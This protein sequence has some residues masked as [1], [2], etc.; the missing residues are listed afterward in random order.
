MET[1][2]TPHPL[3]QELQN[4]MYA[5]RL[6]VGR[7]MAEAQVNPSTWSRWGR[8]TPPNLGTLQRVAEAVNKLESSAT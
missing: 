8:G 3:V 4:R 2:T 6:K 1:N 5:A 7:V